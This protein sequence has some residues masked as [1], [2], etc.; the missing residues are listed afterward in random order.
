MCVGGGRAHP[1]RKNRSMEL[2]ELVKFQHWQ[3]GF[4]DITGLVFKIKGKV[5]TPLPPH[6]LRIPPPVMSHSD[7]S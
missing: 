2:S 4:C 1:K 7:E 3:L 5:L 6:S